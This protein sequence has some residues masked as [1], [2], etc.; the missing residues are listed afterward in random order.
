MTDLQDFLKEMGL[1]KAKP[2]KAK[3]AQRLPD[4][5]M[6]HVILLQVRYHTN[7]TN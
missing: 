2:V 3:P 5:L 7:D 6:I 4:A 1:D